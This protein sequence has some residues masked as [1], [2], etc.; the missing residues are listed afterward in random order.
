MDPKKIE[1]VLQEQ[2]EPTEG[3]S[4]GIG[5][6]NVVK[7]LRLFYG[8]EDTVRIESVLGSYTKVVLNLPKLRGKEHDTGLNR[9]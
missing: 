8:V 2:Y 3:H 9:G 7:R 4:T 6:S 5:F 1:Q